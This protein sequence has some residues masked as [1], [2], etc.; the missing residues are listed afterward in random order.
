MLR[1]LLTGL[2]GT[3]A[4]APQVDFS[5]RAEPETLEELLAS[6]DYDPALE[7]ALIEPQPYPDLDLSKS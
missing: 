5:P 2:F 4:E 1:R 6:L 7:Q 3:R